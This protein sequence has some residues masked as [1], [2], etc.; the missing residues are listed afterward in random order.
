MLI[1]QAKYNVSVEPFDTLRLCEA[2]A[3]RVAMIPKANVPKC[4]LKDQ[5]PT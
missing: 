4:I 2:A 3:E 1:G 5:R